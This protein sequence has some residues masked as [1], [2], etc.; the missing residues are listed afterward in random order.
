MISSQQT[1]KPEDFEHS[2]PSDLS[3]FLNYQKK[4]IEDDDADSSDESYLN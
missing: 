1:T 4:L 3:K 2:S